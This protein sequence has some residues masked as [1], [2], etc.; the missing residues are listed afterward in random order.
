MHD[1]VHTA[2]VSMAVTVAAKE[3]MRKSRMVDV[4]HG[5]EDPEDW[6]PEDVS[7]ASDPLTVEEMD[8]RGI[9]FYVDRIQAQIEAMLS[10]EG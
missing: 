2:W 10:E 5:G 6:N 7:I 3:G 4:L 9:Q 1:K 8:E